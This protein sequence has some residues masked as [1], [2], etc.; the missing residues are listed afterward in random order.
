MNNRFDTVSFLLKIRHS[1][2]FDLKK[3]EKN[4][5]YLYNNFC[6]L[7]TYLNDVEEDDDLDFCEHLYQNVLTSA[8]LSL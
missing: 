2:Q 8:Y 4:F 6:N 7:L 5:S 3:S 1:Q